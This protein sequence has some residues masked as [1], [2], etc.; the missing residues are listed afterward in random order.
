MTYVLLFLFLLA[1]HR[2]F[3]HHLLIRFEPICFKEQVETSALRAISLAVAD[4]KGI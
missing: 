3:Y 1:C 2:P 4:M